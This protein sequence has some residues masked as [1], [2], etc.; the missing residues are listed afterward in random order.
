MVGGF[1]VIWMLDVLGLD[2]V[3]VSVLK[4]NFLFVLFLFEEVVS[5]DVLFYVLVQVG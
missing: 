1:F 3:L 4:V 5:V 2:D